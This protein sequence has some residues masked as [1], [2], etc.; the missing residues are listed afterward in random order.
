LVGALLTPVV[1][2][3]AATN[4]QSLNGI[5]A[6]A[7]FLVATGTDANLSIKITSSSPATNFFQPVWTGTLQPAR[8]GT[9]LSSI[10]LGDILY[11]SATNTLATLGINTTATRYLSNTGP[12]S[13]PAWA[14]INLT[15]GV[16]GVLP[17]SN[18]GT[19]ISSLTKGNLLVATNGTTL[20]TLTVGQDGQVLVASSTQ[21]S[22]VGWGTPYNAVEL[23]RLSLRNSSN[24]VGYYRLE[25]TTDELGLHN[26]TN[27]NSVAFDAAKFNNGADGG[28]SN[29][30]EYLDTGSNMGI[31]GGSITISCWF[32]VNTN[33]STNLTAKICSQNSDTSKVQYYIDIY[34]N[35]GTMEVR[36]G[37]NRVG[38]SQVLVSR[39]IDL[40]DGVFHSLILTYD[41]SSTNLEFFI[42]NVSAGITSDSGNGVNALGNDFSILANPNAAEF[43]SGRVDDAAVFN[44]ALKQDEVFLIAKG[45]WSM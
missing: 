2:A 41:A 17:V 29:S 45:L 26:L 44:R 25:G 34:N 32:K 23:N 42:D 8:G 43:T 37:R 19:G 27:H 16:T 15:N 30:N 3:H 12:S 18:G 40:N 31:D 21:A 11:G 38:S 7:E 10:S 13:T 33:P 5:S 14:Q 20:A 35:N 36:G 1:F 39:N 6:A 22:G 9:G 24:L 28:S 4:I